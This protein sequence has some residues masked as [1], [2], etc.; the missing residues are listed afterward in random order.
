MHSV[1][2]VSHSPADKALAAAAA[3]ESRHSVYLQVTRVHGTA[4]SW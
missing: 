2:V 3:E 1:A 4:V